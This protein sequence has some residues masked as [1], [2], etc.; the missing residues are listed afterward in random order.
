M[1]FNPIIVIVAVFEFFIILGMAGLFFWAARTGFGE[2]DGIFTA[3]MTHDE[4]RKKQYLVN[5]E[6]DRICEVPY[7]WR[8]LS[9][10]RRMKDKNAE[11]L[12]DF[13]IK[14]RGKK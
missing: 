4:P 1:N 6:T 7:C 9:F 11:Y 13:C 12:Y 14:F 8:S 3:T 10:F 5:S 2:Y